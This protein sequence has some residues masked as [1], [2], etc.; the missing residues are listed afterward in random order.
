MAFTLTNGFK[1]KLKT[2][3]AMLPVS[4]AQ[5]IIL[6]LFGYMRN[7]APQEYI[8][9]HIRNLHNLKRSFLVAGAIQD[10]LYGKNMQ[11]E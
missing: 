11:D 6:R 3:L 2:S 1:P 9:L 7:E 4:T 5:S 10:E 8:K